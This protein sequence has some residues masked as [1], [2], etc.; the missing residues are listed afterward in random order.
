MIEEVATR[1]VYWNI[2]YH[3]ALYLFLFP[4]PR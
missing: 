1:E 3:Q 4:N 2:P